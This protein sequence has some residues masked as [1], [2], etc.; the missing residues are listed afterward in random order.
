[1][2]RATAPTVAVR[3]EVAH[4]AVEWLVTLQ[5]SDADDATR[6]AW[7]RWRD[8][9]PEH[10]RAWAHIEAVNARL[11][12]LRGVASPLASTVAS[13]ALT[14]PRSAGRRHAVRALATLFVGGGV[15]WMTREHTPLQGWLAD[16]ATA[17]GEQRRLTLDDGTHLRLNT[18]TA[19]D[20]AFS[21]TERRVVLKRGEIDIET[22]RD[23]ALTPRPFVVA[24]QAATLRPLGTRFVV[25]HLTDAGWIG[26]TEGAVSVRP[27]ETVAAE[28]IVMA[29]QAAQFTARSVAAPAPLSD[30][31]TAWTDGMLVA[32]DMRLDAFLADV[33]RYR[34]GHLRCDPAI[35]DL[36]VSGTFPIADTDRILDALRGMLPVRI[37]FLT[38]YWTTVLPA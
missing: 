8:Q 7:R 23:T 34:P 32:A 2:T 4:A 10:A 38:R 20:V 22:A 25:R 16:A 27:A 35:A 12:R 33:D 6:A 26:V 9:H 24:T 3:P 19:I 29:G 13:A 5:G 14:P 37:H 11:A 21:A 18:D 17:V 28:R 36:R 30:A 1:M 15:A 31:A